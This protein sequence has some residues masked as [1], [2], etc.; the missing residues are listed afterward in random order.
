MFA[1]DL[2]KLASLFEEKVEEFVKEAAPKGVLD[3]K[4]WNKIEKKVLKYKKKYT[5]PY[6]VVMK[7]YLDAG[8]KLSQKSKKK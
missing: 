6:A 4:L 5:E 8:G 2:L 1:K 3:K 7:A